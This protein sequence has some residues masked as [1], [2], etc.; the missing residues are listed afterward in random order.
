MRRAYR[1]QTFFPFFLISLM[2]FVPYNKCM[3][4][5]RILPM[6][7]AANHNRRAAV[8]LLQ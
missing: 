6:G 3:A 1:S 5:T 8:A 2:L 7:A 4:A